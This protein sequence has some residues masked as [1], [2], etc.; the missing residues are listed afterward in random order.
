MNI[1]PLVVIFRDF[2]IPDALDAA[3]ALLQRGVVAFELTFGPDTLLP[4]LADLVDLVG[5]R[6]VV[7]AGTVMSTDQVSF[8]AEAGARFVVS[9]HVDVRLIEAANRRTLQS[10]PG[11]LTA[12]EVVTAAVAGADG[13]KLFPIAC[14]G[15]ADYVRQL[16]GPLPTIPLLVT[17]G[18]TP[19]IAAGCLRAGAQS[20]AVTANLIDAAACRER[21]WS[22][23]AESAGPYLE[24]IDTG[25]ISPA[26]LG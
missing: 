17:G 12:T 23:L 22:R 15:G 6:G 11:A 20:V 8:A 25:L 1:P 4:G 21:R 10:I 13:V 7:G 26:Q 24:A 16:R 5:D 3:E 9:P 14:V 19:T 2:S 18:V